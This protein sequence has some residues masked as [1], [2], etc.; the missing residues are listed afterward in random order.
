[1][2]SSKALNRIEIIE[3]S[4]ELRN[5]IAHAYEGIDL[6]IVEDVIVERLP[7]IMKST[8]EVLSTLK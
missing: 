8:E 1:M 7:I 6:H 2:Y 3:G 5:F 4:Y